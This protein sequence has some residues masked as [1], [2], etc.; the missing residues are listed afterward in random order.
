MTT[1]YTVIDWKSYVFFY[2]KKHYLFAI[3]RNE[4]FVKWLYEYVIDKISYKDC[5]IYDDKWELNTKLASIILEFN[6]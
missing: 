5:D 4:L 1:Q 2:D 6:K 3:T